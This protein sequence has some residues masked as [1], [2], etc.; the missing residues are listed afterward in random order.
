MPILMFTVMPAGVGQ[1]CDL[2]SC[3]VKVDENI[4]LEAYDDHVRID[5]R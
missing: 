4:S 2:L 5:L 1:L 3:L